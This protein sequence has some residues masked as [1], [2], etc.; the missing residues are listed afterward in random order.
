MENA[1]FLQVGVPLVG[2]VL[3]FVVQALG[4]TSERTL[5]FTALILSGLIF[6]LR[7]N[8]GEGALFI[9]GIIFGLIIEIGLR[10]LGSQQTW[11]KA[12]FFGVPYWLPIAWG[13]GFVIITR[14]GVFIRQLPF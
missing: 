14:L 12:S 6:V 1:V 2:F 8:Q 7:Y 10:R 5:T 9:T 13:I 11:H 4:K 3:F